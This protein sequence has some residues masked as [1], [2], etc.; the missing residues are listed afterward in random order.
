M[1]ESIQVPRANPLALSLEAAIAGM[2]EWRV[3][4]IRAWLE[5]RLTPAHPGCVQDLAALE[6]TAWWNS[7]G[8]EG[9]VGATSRLV[10]AAR[11]APGT[12][13]PLLLFV[14]F[15]SMLAWEQE[16]E[17]DGI[18]GVVDRIEAEVGAQERQD[19]EVR[20]AL[21]LLVFLL[22][23]FA[24]EAA[25][26]GGQLSDWAREAQSAASRGAELVDSVG[27]SGHGP[28]LAY[29]A[30]QA[31]G[32]VDYYTAVAGAARAAA[33]VPADR[34]RSLEAAITE[35][36]RVEEGEDPIDRSELRAH[37]LS[38][39][40]LRAAVGRP[41]LEIASGRLVAL[42]PFALRSLSA[43]DLRTRLAGSEQWL[44]GGVPVVSHRDSLPINDMWH[45]EDPLG[46]GYRGST[47]RLPEVLLSRRDEDDLVALPEIWLSELG[48][49]VLRLEI[50]LTDCHPFAL[51][52]VL[53]ILG[54]EG[55]DL[56]LVGE[57]VRSVL[58]PP[59]DHAW[60]SAATFATSV[61]TDLAI[62]LC[63]PPQDAA[64][65]FVPSLVTTVVILDQ[66]R[67]WCPATGE[68]RPVDDGD[69]VLT[70]FGATLL[71]RPT[72]IL[73]SIAQ[74]ARDGTGP[75]LTGIPAV[76]RS[77]WIARSENTATVAAFGIPS[78][79]VDMLSDCVVFTATLPGLFAGWNHDLA[80]FNSR[81]A[82]DLADVSGRLDA[83]ADP[84]TSQE[85]KTLEHDLESRQL[86]LH[87]FVTRCR[88]VILFVESP[89]LLSSPIMRSL[90][91]R[92]LDSAEH[93][94]LVKGFNDAATALAGGRLE[95]VL[96]KVR[97]RL[98]TLE[99][100]EANRRERKVR[101][102]TD[103]LVAGVTVAGI[104]GVASLIQAGYDLGPLAT[105][106]MVLF[107]VVVSVCIGLAVWL[108]NR[109][110]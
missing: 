88:S 48:N 38:L 34:G 62:R 106:F 81:L 20:A 55:A 102:V 45:T 40:A 110:D 73:T 46:R 78:Y 93:Q 14:R 70:L 51:E 85:V 75:V 3:G 29:V 11:T 43:Q 4:P 82:D 7:Q 98:E 63:P 58:P 86:R 72:G 79:A 33:R 35:L 60:T 71:T 49:H 66:V 42:F 37:R 91:D 8:S 101:L 44:L 24:V 36:R 87:D 64:L 16:W 94:R 50:R 56:D 107:V 97:T 13:A 17:V 5:E 18:R 61:L 31:A 21:D 68:R 22:A 104:S 90:I 108:N 59:H 25:S 30:D 9:L 57:A 89:T 83:S 23:E 32:E 12:L 99:E 67:A 41:W 80:L 76:G 27:R 53:R 95:T 2:E 103:A 92:L 39:E 69:E 15:A 74:W 54:P 109:R 96:G 105:V 84:L 47:L 19:P 28:V 65:V 100:L 10:G 1:H 52:H 77:G 6:A 26:L